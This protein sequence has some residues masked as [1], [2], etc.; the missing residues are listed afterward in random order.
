MKFTP[1][2][3]I[4]GHCIPVDP[5][6]LSWKLKSLNYTAR[7]IELADA[8]N[9]HMPEHV[10]TLVADALNEEGKALR[11]ARVLI[12]GAAYKP[13]TDDL[14]ES[15]ALDVMVELLERRAEVRYHDPYVPEVRLAE[16]G[17]VLQSEALT[18][19]ALQAA[20]CVLVITNHSVFDWGMVRKHAR[21]IVDTR[22]AL[23][24]THGTARVVKL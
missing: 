10:V 12:L 7:F 22:N 2:P 9:S 23:K 13:D 11:G 15:P 18:A 8:I 4:G 21:L 17:A 16:R 14:R 24:G 5:L 6:Y 1:G 20:D 3:G 19:A